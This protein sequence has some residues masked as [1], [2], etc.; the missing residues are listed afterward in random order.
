MGLKAAMANQSALANLRDYR[1]K[2]TMAAAEM[3]EKARML[4]DANRSTNLTNFVQGL[5]DIGSENVGWNQL[6]WAIDHGV[7]GPMQGT[8]NKGYEKSRKKKNG[9]KLLT[10]KI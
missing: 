1:L 4:A 10:K 3:R 2:G 8:P 5:G 7:F 6:Q 9:G